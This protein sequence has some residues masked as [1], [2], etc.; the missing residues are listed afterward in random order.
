MV[1][2]EIYIKI[3]TEDTSSTVPLTADTGLYTADDTSI[4]ADATSATTITE[5]YIYKRLDLFK[6]EKISLTSSIQNVNDLS[7]VFTDYSQ[8]FTVPASKNNNQI[9]NYWNESGVNDGFDQRIRYDAI[10]EIN[11]IPFKKGQIQIEKANEKNNRVE[12]FS[13]TFYGKVKQ[14]KDLF[15]EDKLNVLD[16][17]SLNHPYSFDEVRKRIDGNIQD[18]V[19]YPLVGN[20][21]KYE[22]V[23]GGAN[24]VT[25]GG[26]L[27][28]SIVY[29]D[30][31]PAIPVS[32]IFEFIEN[33]YSITFTSSLF[34][35]S[36]W[37]DLYLYCKNVEQQIVYSAPVFIFTTEF[38]ANY[39]Y[40]FNQI[41]CTPDNLLVNYR[42]IVKNELGVTINVFN[43]LVGIQ[44][45]TI[46]NGLDYFN[47]AINVYIETESALN[48]TVSLVKEE[49]VWDGTGWTTTTYTESIPITTAGDINLAAN[50]PDIKIVDFFTGIIKIFNLTIT[51]IS[52][53]EFNLEP[54]EF[55]YSYGKYID[56]NSYVINDNVDLERTKLFKKLTFTHEKSENVLNNYFRNTF[57]R[58][59]DYG[60]LIF[61][62]NLSNEST[63]YEIKSPF[64]NVMW[65]KASVGEFQTTSLIDKDLKPYKPKPI[66]MYKNSFQPL[67]NNI[68]MFTGSSYYNLVNYQRFSNE[69]F[70]N[71]DIASLNFGSDTSTWLTSSTTN[72]S[73]FELWYRNYISGLY[74]IRCRIVKLKSIIP[75]TMLSDIKLNDKIVYKDKKYII[76]QFTADLTTGEVDFEL[77]SDFREVTNST[78]IGGKFALKQ[79]F[80][81]DNNA[82]NLEVTILKQ[83]SEKYDVEYLGTSYESLDNYTDDTFIVPIDS[84]TTG[85]IAYKQII[86]TYYNPRVIQY[87]N[88]IQDA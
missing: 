22:Y 55:Y 60:D 18:N 23:T 65:E 24:D 49:S 74:N 38:L 7:K 37:T 69:L 88:I 82:Q 1:N 40:I 6:D 8:S 83:N 73:L 87:V 62:D 52:E 48:I 44:T 27:A 20:K 43:N 17:S 41:T 56:I 25:V 57:Q 70:I 54:L 32:K 67:S 75:V 79:I 85:D 13:V 86:V 21:N 5:N 68:K 19:K 64:E 51:A 61:E 66:L 14:I 35:T 84:N 26:S 59:Y 72:D 80:K 58:G 3:P 10:I 30:L 78:A 39:T 2:V 63:T 15:K 53:T 47:G 46:F 9:F 11:T 42:V 36:Y 33:K 16:Y 29:S 50:V 31:F 34:N 76:N 4:T 71:N 81:I 77:I 12:S 28:K 45:L